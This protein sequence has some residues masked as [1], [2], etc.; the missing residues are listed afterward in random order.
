M[1]RTDLIEKL[2]YLADV[3]S[4]DAKSFME[5]FLLH[6]S[7]ILDDSIYLNLPDVGNFRFQ[8]L[9]KKD[10]HK[11]E[12]FNAVFFSESEAFFNT[13]EELVFNVTGNPFSTTEPID[14]YF[15]MGIGKP[16][17]S[18][19]LQYST[20]IEDYISPVDAIA[21][22]EIK[23]EN[24]I[25]K[26]SILKLPF[27]T[28]ENVRNKTS[29]EFPEDFQLL[30]SD[31]LPEKEEV[32]EDGDNIPWDFGG[33]WT[34]EYEEHQLL[35][36]DVFDNIDNSKVIEPGRI[37]ELPEEVLPP[38]PEDNI[39]F[40]DLEKLFPEPQIEEQEENE[41]PFFK[42]GTPPQELQSPKED[43][44]DEYDYVSPRTKELNISPSDIERIEGYKTT[45]D[46]AGYENKNE[47]L[48]DLNEFIIDLGS[49]ES[50]SHYVEV[51]K[52][53]EKIQLTEEEPVVNFDF[54]QPPVEKE[55]PVLVPEAEEEAQ[56]KKEP[57]VKTRKKE[58]K[59]WGVLSGILILLIAGLFY[60]K[61][62][63][64]PE[65]LKGKEEKSSAMHPDSEPLVID[66][67]YSVPV[68]YPYNRDSVSS[69]HETKNEAIQQTETPAVAA[70]ETSETFSKAN[71]DNILNKGKVE[72]NQIHGDGLSTTKVS[73]HVFLENSK[74]IVQVSSW[75]SKLKA[76]QE[77]S[78]FSKKGY[79]SF[80]EEAHLPAKGGSWYRVKVGYFNSLSEAESFL[81]RQ[82]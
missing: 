46:F 81:Q 28:L 12:Y 16:V 2:V 18:S 47:K 60:I 15:S 29:I 76:E 1:T 27:Y 9:R 82:K 4:S 61:I 7:R 45:K 56:I 73:D 49:E 33:K 69:Q 79:K 22:I 36:D 75:R 26:G 48:S 51:K 17:I 37:T 10:K 30:E 77:V 67:D 50:T 31:Y 54:L 53:R 64:F 66:R 57:A 3:Q 35:N 40:N 80:I 32:Y 59:I 44:A 23:I 38:F 70:L 55:V 25:A 58:S 19:R 11:A 39:T 34:R 8:R 68:T 14:A 6:L 52:E 20:E 24:L 62:A 78:S 42:S 63:G 41:I 65:W 72:K 71:P 43:T 74:Y 21:L 5:L 13:P